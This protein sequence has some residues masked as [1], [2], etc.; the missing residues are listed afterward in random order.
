MDS[1]PPG[2]SVHGILQTRIL[3]TS[4]Q[5]GGLPCPP[6]GDLPDPEIDLA[7]LTVPALTVGFFPTRATWEAL[8]NMHTHIHS[9]S[10]IKWI[11]PPIAPAGLARANEHRIIGEFLLSSWSSLAAPLNSGSTSFHFRRLASLS[12]VIVPTSSWRAEASLLSAAWQSEPL[13]DSPRTVHAPSESLLVLIPPGLPASS[14]LFSKMLSVLWDSPGAS[15][16]DHSGLL[17]SR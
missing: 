13:L 1:S 12:V 14:V 8:T 16:S 10:W 4:W 2:S 9:L 17:S 7:A 3:D 15:L 5:Q 6:P 11:K